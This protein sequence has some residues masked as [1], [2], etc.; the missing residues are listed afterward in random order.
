MN[1]GEEVTLLI[2][3]SLDNKSVALALVDSISVVLDCGDNDLIGN[4]DSNDVDSSPNNADVA[5]VR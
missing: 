5:F 2:F 3:S 1:A 4:G